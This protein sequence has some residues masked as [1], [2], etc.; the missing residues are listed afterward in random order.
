MKKI[1]ALGLALTMMMSM[2]AACSTTK[3]PAAKTAEELTA[4]LEN[5]KTKYNGTRQQVKKAAATQVQ[6]YVYH[7]SRQD[8][9][10]EETGIKRER[11]SP[12]AYYWSWLEEK[13]FIEHA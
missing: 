8:D 6:K 10:S 3:A 12:F 13:G 5:Y 7:M 4:L 9:P 2:L 11:Q 1:L